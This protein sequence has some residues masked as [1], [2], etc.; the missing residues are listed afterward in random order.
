[1]AQS[2]PASA[3]VRQALTAIVSELCEVDAAQIGEDFVLASAGRLRS[4]LGRATLDAKIRRRLG[5]RIENLHTLRTFGDLEAAVAAGSS[6]APAPPSQIPKPASAEMSQPM[7]P[8]RSLAKGA[9][10]FLSAQ[11]SNWSEAPASSGAQVWSAAKLLSAE[12]RLACGID[13]ESISSLPE[14]KDYWEEP[15]YKAN[16]TPAE[17]AYCVGQA[18]PRMHFAARWCAKEALKKCLPAYTQWEMKRIEVVRGEAG[19]PY[20]RLTEDGGAKTPP[21]ALSLTHSEDWALAMV[22]SGAE[23]PAPTSPRP[24]GSATGS[25]IGLCLSLA[26]LVCSL[27]ALILALI[28]W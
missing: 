19:R 20:L 22:V 17:I 6:G 15:F 4:S 5:V 16:F 18:N 2:E 23:R 14:A 11:R 1:V 24:R 28:R 10:T 9:P 3:G 7:P 8:L 26:A 25:R 12:S 27:L 13:V 21:V